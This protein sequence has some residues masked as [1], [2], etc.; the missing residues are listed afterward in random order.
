MKR[1]LGIDLGSSR[2]GL[3]LSD[4]LKIFASPFLNLKF[5]GNKKLIAELLVIIDQQDIEEV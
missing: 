1:L 2:V 5:T 4:P 3:A